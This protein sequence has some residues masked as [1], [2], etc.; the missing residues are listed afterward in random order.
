MTAQEL[1]HCVDAAAAA[2][3]LDLGDS[4]PGVLNYF[5]LAS[6]FAEVVQAVPLTPHDESAM[7]FIPVVPFGVR[8]DA[9]A[10][11]PEMDTSAAEGT[12]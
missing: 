4:R 8:A 5:A 1:A 7:A 12:P 3:G 9:Q 11:R 10:D 2:L 6:G